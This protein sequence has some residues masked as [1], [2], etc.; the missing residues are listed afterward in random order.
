MKD[1]GEQNLSARQRGIYRRV[2]AS[3]RAFNDCS[4]MVL[5]VLLVLRRKGR[6]FSTVRATVAMAG[7]RERFARARH[8]V[9]RNCPRLFDC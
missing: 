3:G 2:L 4:S 6:N 9:T 5:L 1:P 8:P 7:N